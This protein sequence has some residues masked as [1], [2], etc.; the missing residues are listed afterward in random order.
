MAKYEVETSTGSVYFI[1]TDK[2]QW[3]KNSYFWEP[4]NDLAVGDWDGT[5]TNI[6]D[7]RSWPE[8]ELPEVGR[9]MYIRGFGMN[10]WWLS[11]PIVEVREVEEWG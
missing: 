3:A 11:T 2:K 5:R 1:D 6:P 9:N 10:D 7:F 4:L 8:V